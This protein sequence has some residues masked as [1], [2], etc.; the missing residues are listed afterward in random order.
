MI[1]RAYVNSRDISGACTAAQ[2]S[3]IA[4][5]AKRVLKKDVVV[6]NDADARVLGYVGTR[7][8]LI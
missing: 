6:L 4:A 8:E 5:K 2:A 3:S 7:G 1:Y